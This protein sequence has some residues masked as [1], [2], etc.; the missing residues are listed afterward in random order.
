[1]W[2]PMDGLSL[3]ATSGC[4]GFLWICA[5]F[6]TLRNLWSYLRGVLSTST[7]AKPALGRNGVVVMNQRGIRNI[8]SYTGWFTYLVQSL[9]N[10]YSTP[11]DTTS[12][13]RPFSTQVF[14][15]LL[16]ESL[17]QPTVLLYF[18]P[19]V[20]KNAILFFSWPQIWD[21]KLPRVFSSLPN[22]GFMRWCVYSCSR[23]WN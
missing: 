19:S 12:C 8:L 7:L 3:P 22:I 5:R 1:M 17:P 2:M 18:W 13:G 11:L 21:W 15:D 10:N 6:S 16:Y 9:A 4:C 23:K 14:V 20:P